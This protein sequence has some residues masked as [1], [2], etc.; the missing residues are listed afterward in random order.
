MFK[1]SSVMPVLHIKMKTRICEWDFFVQ[2]ECSY[3]GVF[4]CVCVCVVCVYVCVCV[5]E[6]ERAWVYAYLLHER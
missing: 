1:F 5:R 4:V 2:N 6:R 3:T